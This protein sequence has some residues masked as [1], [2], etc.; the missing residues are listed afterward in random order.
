MTQVLNRQSDTLYLMAKS[1]SVTMVK[2]HP[3]TLVKASLQKSNVRR[4]T[5]PNLGESLYMRRI[6]EDGII[7]FIPQITMK[8]ASVGSNNGSE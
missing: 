6:H 2:N 3:D 4:L 8:S 5:I 1:H 7:E